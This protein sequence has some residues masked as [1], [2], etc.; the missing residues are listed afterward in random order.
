MSI[1]NNLIHRLEIELR[2]H[3]KEMK[4]MVKSVV[5]LEE[6][7]KTQDRLLNEILSQ[8]TTFDGAV[9]E[10]KASSHA[11]IDALEKRQNKIIG[12]MIFSAGC[13]YALFGKG[14][15]VFKGMVGL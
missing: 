7:S 2:D 10:A 9:K 1:E 4:T 5:R 13:V 14:A 15:S 8:I 3:C 12:Y 11:K 6:Q